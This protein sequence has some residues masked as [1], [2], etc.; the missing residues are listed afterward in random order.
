MNSRSRPSRTPG[1]PAGSAPFVDSDP[2]AR[3]LDE[4]L[5]GMR[6]EVLEG[7]WCLVG[8]QGAPDPADLEPVRSGAGPAQVIREGG[9]TTL[10]LPAADAEAALAR[11]PGARIERD[12]AWIR[13]EM[14]MEWELIGF[15]ALVAGRLAAAG[16][17]IGAVCG[18]SRDHLFVAR[19]HLERAREVLSGLFQ[20][21]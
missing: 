1:G 6:W 13:F 2:S 7:D 15:L 11:H 16:V 20:S 12:L 4:A 9:E 17:P 21:R 5:A 19:P 8:F 10:L 18:F 14:A 3:T